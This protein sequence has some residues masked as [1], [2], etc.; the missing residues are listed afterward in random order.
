V[1]GI[2][3]PYIPAA[4]PFVPT[5]AFVPAFPHL[6]YQIYFANQTSSAIAELNTDIRRTL[7]ATLR[8]VASPPPSDFLLSNSSYLA[9]WKNVSTVGIEMMSMMSSSSSVQELL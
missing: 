7:R 8:T 6:A 5:S 9:G 1:V 3:L 4:G 2:T